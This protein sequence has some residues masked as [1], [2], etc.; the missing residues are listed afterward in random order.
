MLRIEKIG[1]SSLQNYPF[2]LRK[3]IVNTSMV[4]NTKNTAETS[5]S[6]ILM[7][8]DANPHHPPLWQQICNRRVGRGKDPKLTERRVR[9]VR[10]AQISFRHF[11]SLWYSSACHFLSFSCSLAFCLP[12]LKQAKMPL[13]RKSNFPFLSFGTT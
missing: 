5:L 11:S 9:N 8:H 1:V 10:L 12:M 4:N 13:A 7:E 2:S 3:N 6:H